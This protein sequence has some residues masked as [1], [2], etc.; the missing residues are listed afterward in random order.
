MSCRSG[1]VRAAAQRA[2]AQRPAG[3]ARSRR[4][5][6]WPAAQ[7]LRA[8]SLGEPLPPPQTSQHLLSPPLSPNHLQQSSLREPAD[9]RL[10]SRAQ[11]RRLFRWTRPIQAGATAP[12][13]RPGTAPT[14]SVC[15]HKASASR[16]AAKEAR[17]R[18]THSCSC[19]ASRRSSG[20]SA[21]I[22]AAAAAPSI[23][24][25]DE[26]ASS[27]AIGRVRDG[28]LACGSSICGPTGNGA[29]ATKRPDA[30]FGS[31]GKR[32]ATRAAA[33]LLELRRRGSDCTA[34]SDARGAGR[35]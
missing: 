15:V 7:C 35:A 22:V 33:K 19:S 29:G 24:A 12:A 9:H 2:D 4:R 21:G 10:P 1:V 5:T 28:A 23:A 13:A 32:P 26:G 14:D 17:E 3:A 31:G 6:R 20:E 30:D 16:R 18:C 11:L 8:G 34:R 25:A 27:S